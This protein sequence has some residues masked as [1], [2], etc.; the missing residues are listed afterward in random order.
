MSE[1][2]GV[3]SECKKCGEKLRQMASASTIC[4]EDCRFS[5]VITFNKT[6]Q[7]GSSVASH[8]LY[9]GVELNS[10]LKLELTYSNNH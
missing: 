7:L 10:N 2:I 3:R 8:H 1:N 9:S 4:D 5:C 6:A